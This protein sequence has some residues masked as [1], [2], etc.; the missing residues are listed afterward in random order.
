MGLELNR[1][2]LALLLAF[3][4]VRA[5]AGSLEGGPLGFIISGNAYVL[6]HLWIV[7][8][9][10]VLLIKASGLN[11]KTAFK[12]V[13]LANFQSTVIVGL[14]LPF[15]LAVLTG[16]AM[17]LPQPYGG[18]AAA[19]GTWEDASGL[20]KT[21]I[22][23]IAL[24]WLLIG[25]ILLVLCEKAFYTRHWLKTGLDANFPLNKFIWRAHAVSHLGL[26]MIVFVMWHDYFGL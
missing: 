14:G 24:G 4:S 25:F 8:T 15:F 16:I 22:G 10:T 3:T 13:F 9:E 6:G 19:L 26:L 18:I 17:Q 11:A 7:F 5:F 12:W 21:Y 2:L 23:F 1:C 20:S